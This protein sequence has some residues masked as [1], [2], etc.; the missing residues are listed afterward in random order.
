MSDSR[1][2]LDA[3]DPPRAAARSPPN[4]PALVAELRHL[5]AQVDALDLPRVRQHLRRTGGSRLGLDRLTL[6]ARLAAPSKSAVRSS[7]GTWC[8]VASDTYVQTSTSLPAP[9]TVLSR[10]RRARSSA[11][12]TS[13][14]RRC[15]VVRSRAVERRLHLG[16]VEA[17]GVAVAGDGLGV[18][19]DTV[20]LAVADRGD[21]ESKRSAS[22][23]RV[24]GSPTFS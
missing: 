18:R 8:S 22:F 21:D 14:T 9:S 5:R 24:K 3:I 1:L 16:D 2:D 6:R 23:W 20:E 11:C 13:A 12:G 7:D 10:P 17:G 4:R 15:Q 19:L